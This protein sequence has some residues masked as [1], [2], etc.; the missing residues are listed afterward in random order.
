MSDAD[1]IPIVKVADIAAYKRLFVELMHSVAIK[2]DC[3]VT[4][5]E[6]TTNTI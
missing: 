1:K 5:N 3:S 6:N 2:C 4:Y